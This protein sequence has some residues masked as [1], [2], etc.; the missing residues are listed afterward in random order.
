MM[1]TMM[2]MM[3]WLTARTLYGSYARG[4]Y[5]DFSNGMPNTY[6]FQGEIVAFCSAAAGEDLTKCSNG[7]I[8]KAA[9]KEVHPGGTRQSNMR[10]APRH[11][12]IGAPPLGA[13]RVVMHRFSTG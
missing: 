8:F 4:N 2:T 12:Q 10:H 7:T 6:F 5:D 11:D 1:M 3:V 9:L 13:V